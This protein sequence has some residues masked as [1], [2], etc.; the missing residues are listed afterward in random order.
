MIHHDISPSLETYVHTNLPL[1]YVPVT[2]TDS[3][4]DGPMSSLITSL[5][6]CQ[7]NNIRYPKEKKR[8]G[9]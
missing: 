5:Q 6:V 7:I 1:V 9:E 3:S 2:Q 4:P 8:D